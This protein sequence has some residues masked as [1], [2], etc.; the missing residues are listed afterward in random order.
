MYTTQKNRILCAVTVFCL[1]ALISFGS[2]CQHSQR[3]TAKTNDAPDDV[4]TVSIDREKNGAA[5]SSE[6]A[7]QRD[8]K[9]NP[10]VFA[11]EVAGASARPDGE[12][13]Q[14]MV[15]S[16]KQAAIIDAFVKALIESRQERGLP[17]ADFTERFGPRLTVVHTTKNDGPWVE[18][19]ILARGIENAF[20]LHNGRLENPPYDFGMVQ[21]VF[22]E[23]GG[24]FTLLTSDALPT[25][26][27][28][29]AKVGCYLPPKLESVM[30]GDVS[31]AGDSAPT[32]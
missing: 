22:A 19:R 12:A 15:A 6:A 18:V 32:P 29:V 9:K 16:A 11:F 2:A 24:E 28:Y 23:S 1:L 17:T 14:E 25:S 7:R 4:F 5:A 26:N 3:T 13:D 20:I 31:Q 27:Q 30:A 21:R 10:R 8:A